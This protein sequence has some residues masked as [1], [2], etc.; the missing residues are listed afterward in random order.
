MI[1]ANVLIIDDN[2]G[3][4]T[5][6]KVLLS[7]HYKKIDTASNPNVIPSLLRE[8]HFDIIILDMNFSAGLRSGN[9]GIYWLRRIRKIDNSTSIIMITA[10]A[11]IE[12]A[13]KSLK[14]GATD[15]II[16][17]WH[18]D[19]LLATLKAAYQLSKSK[20]EVKQLKL[21]ERNLKNAMIRPRE[22]I[23]APDSSMHQVMKL[24]NKVAG[25]DANVLITGEHGTGKGLIAEE[26]HRSSKRCH[27]ALITVDM[28]AIIETLFESELYGHVKGAFTDAREDK[29]GK[30]ETAD[31]GSLFLDEIGNLPLHLQ[32]KLLVT[33]Q[34][35]SVSRV[36]ANRTIPIDIRLISATNRD[37][38]QLVREGLFREDLLFRI[39]TITIEIPPL[40][41]RKSDIPYLA[42]FYLKKYSDK[43]GRGNLKLNHEAQQ[44]LIN[45]QW[46]GNIRELQHA[47]EKAVIL[48]DDKTLGPTDFFFKSEELIEENDASVT[49]DEMEKRMIT[50]ALRRHNGNYSAVANQLGITR[51]TLYN[52]IKKW[53]FSA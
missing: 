6:L 34:N 28:G 37:L 42:E 5:A 8:Q 15:F 14:E 22:I 13:V 50:I 26:L 31:K 9:E 49:L 27:E 35:W 2:T 39:N 12:L 3:V 29:A 17:P 19:K 21:K 44:T 30:F 7:T 36:G 32:A 20:K 1:N 33:L 25:T 24:V 43:Y 46:P 18:N 4:L 10:Y 11:D 16:K 23:A 53:G 40:R 38:E 51:Q 47:M 45:Y 41:N 48:A 52:K